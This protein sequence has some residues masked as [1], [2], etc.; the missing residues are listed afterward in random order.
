MKVSAGCTVPISRLIKEDVE[1][2]VTIKDQVP[3]N[4]RCKRG[5]EWG[6]GG[7]LSFRISYRTGCLFKDPQQ[8]KKGYCKSE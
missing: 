7:G 1:Q 6:G 5:R 3:H 4:Q 8:R 2:G